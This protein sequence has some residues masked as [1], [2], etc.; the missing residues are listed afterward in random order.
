MSPF[1]Y[2]QKEAIAIKELDSLPKQLDM[3]PLI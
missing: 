1:S 3:F 2:I